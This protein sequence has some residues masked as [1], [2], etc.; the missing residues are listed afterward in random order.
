MQRND[1]LANVLRLLYG[2]TTAYSWYPT[3]IALRHCSPK[4]RYMF[5]VVGHENEDCAK[6]DVCFWHENSR[7]R[8]FPA[9]RTADG[10]AGPIFASLAQF[11][12]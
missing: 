6:R 8:G 11:V 5:V 4:W 3:P 12:S 1:A 10:V 7:K 2:I 9:V